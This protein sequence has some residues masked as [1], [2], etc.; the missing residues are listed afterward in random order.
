M[1]LGAFQASLNIRDGPETETSRSRDGL[2]TYVTSRLGLVSE[3]L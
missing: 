3:K 2:E 1:A